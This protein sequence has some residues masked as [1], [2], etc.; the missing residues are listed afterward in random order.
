L[1]AM[2]SGRPVIAYKKGGAV[3]T[4]IPKKTGILFE[5]QSPWSL[6]DVVRDFNDKDFNPEEIRKRALDFDIKLFK[7]RIEKYIFDSYRNF[8]DSRENYYKIN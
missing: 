1:E 4:V 5:D 3:E 8:K 7:N 2:A 6:V